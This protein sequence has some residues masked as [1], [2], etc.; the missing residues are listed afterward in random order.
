MFRFA[1]KNAPAKPALL[2]RTSP[3]SYAK[4]AIAFPLSSVALLLL[5][6]GCAK[7]LLTCPRIVQAPPPPLPQQHPAVVLFATDR[8]PESREQL[9]FSADLNPSGTHLS[10]GA[11]CVDPQGG[12]AECDSPSRWLERGDLLEKISKSRSD[13]VLFVHGFNYSFDE[14]LE[15]ALRIVERADFPA[16]AVAYSWPSQARVSAYGLDYDM[17]EWTVDHLTLFIHD[18]AAAMPEGL[19]LHIV[20]H[21]MGTRAALLAL[22]RL[23]LPEQRLGQLVL[24]APD[25]DSRIFAELV[26]HAAP[27]QRRTLYVSKHDLALSASAFLH[28]GTRR[29]GDVTR[30][31]LVVKDVD[32]IDMSPIKAGMLGHSLQDYSQLMFAD[33]GAVLKDQT[34]ADRKLTACTVKSIAQANA[35]H[36]TSQ[37]C[38]VYLLPR[39]SR[40]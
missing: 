15:F 32:T 17:S 11:K 26:L 35:D 2:R 40:R 13:V 28:S 25:V 3:S 4:R 20:T 10:Y 16:T 22:S 36:G 8:L 21:S 29:A 30:D 33:L 23:E 37:P 19:R 9:L 18:V 14:S 34:V 6:C 31:Y 1:M 38:T 27:F 24:I 12:K 39:Q 5:L 7:P